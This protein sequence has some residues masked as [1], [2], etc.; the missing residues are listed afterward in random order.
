MPVAAALVGSLAGFLCFNRPPATIYLGDTGSTLI[1]LVVGLV[2]LEGGSNS[3]GQLAVAVPLVLMTIPVWDTTLAIVRRKLTGRRFDAADRGHLHH[4]LLE[5]GFRPWQALAIVAVLSATT[6]TAAIV[7]ARTGQGYLGWGTTIAVIVLLVSRRWFGELEM[8]LVKTAAI[9]Q[10]VGLASRLSLST[11]VLRRVRWIRPDRM[12]FALAWQTLIEELSS[13]SVRRFELRL[14]YDG[15]LRAVHVWSSDDEDPPPA[16]PWRLS[17]SFDGD[18]Q[19]TCEVVVQGGDAAH[20]EAWYLPRVAHLLRIFGRHW[21][22]HPEQ[23]PDKQQELG[24]PMVA[25]WLRWQRRSA[26]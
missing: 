8:T 4:R 15:E 19:N 14:R 18:Q 26:A 6:G 1:G 2:C 20:C 10:F 17:M 16:H 11:N 13:C 22:A 21:A 9:R 7:A 25:H 12:G 24:L 3:S 5:I 23:V